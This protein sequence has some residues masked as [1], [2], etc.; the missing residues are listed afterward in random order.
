MVCDVIQEGIL[1]PNKTVNIPDIN[2]HFPILTDKDR[3][4]IEYAK[5]LGLILYMLLCKK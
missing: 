4:D 2:L 3:Q 1:K 5:E